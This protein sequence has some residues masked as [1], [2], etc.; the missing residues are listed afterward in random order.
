MNTMTMVSRQ[1][2]LLAGVVAMI[3]ALCVTGG[4]L[5]LAEHYAQAGASSQ[6]AGSKLAGQAAQDANRDA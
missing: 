1:V 3:A 6:A 2:R 4:S 5:S